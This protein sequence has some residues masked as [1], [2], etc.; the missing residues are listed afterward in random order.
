M[1]DVAWGQ[2]IKTFSSF[3]TVI[4]ELQ[5]FMKFLLN[6]IRIMKFHFKTDRKKD[7]KT[8]ICGHYVLPATPEG[9][10]RRPLRPIQGVSHIN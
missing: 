2:K 7:R 6:S 4:L 5:I 10:A 8:V 3:E 9:S 1:T